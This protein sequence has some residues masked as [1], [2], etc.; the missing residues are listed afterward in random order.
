MGSVFVL[1][2]LA[3]GREDDNGSIGACHLVSIG[4]GFFVCLASYN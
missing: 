2:R 4:I 1:D 3:D